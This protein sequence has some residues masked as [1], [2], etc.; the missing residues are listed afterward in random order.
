MSVCESATRPTKFC[1]FY[2]FSLRWR[3]GRAAIRGP[4]S[5]RRVGRSF[6][7]RKDAVDQWR[8]SISECCPVETVPR[9]EE[10]TQ[11]RRASRILALSF[12]Q[13]GKRSSFTSFA[14]LLALKT[15][16]FVFFFVCFFCKCSKGEMWLKSFSFS[17]QQDLRP[18]FLSNLKKYPL[19]HVKRLQLK[20]KLLPL[21]KGKGQTGSTL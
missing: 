6:E 5:C 1:A 14:R 7:G 8:L 10:F 19:L 9:D 3:R 15:A 21:A 2:T 20:L 18:L 12:P 11:R 17:V 13:E 4:L 16:A